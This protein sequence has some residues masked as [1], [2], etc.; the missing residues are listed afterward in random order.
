MRRLSSRRPERNFHHV[1]WSVCRSECARRAATRRVSRL[2]G[3]AGRACAGSGRDRL[4]GLGLEPPH[5]LRRVPAEVSA[6]LETEG[7]GKARVVLGKPPDR[8]RA[9][10]GQLG[11]LAGAGG[12]G[13]RVS[14]G[15]KHE[16]RSKG[17]GAP[18]WVL[19][20]CTSLANREDIPFL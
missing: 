6:L 14:R 8:G 11:Q 7:L 12:Q 4:G 18:T 2:W 15:L 19:V 20:R 5:H 10:P 9:E 1:D 16:K 17:Q 3:K 13:Q